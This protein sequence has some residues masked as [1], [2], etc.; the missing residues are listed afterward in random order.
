MFL[1]VLFVVSLVVQG[2]T[3]IERLISDALAV[4][5]HNEASLCQ[6]VVSGAMAGDFGM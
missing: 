2:R 5:A 3:A 1:A 4:A 6:V